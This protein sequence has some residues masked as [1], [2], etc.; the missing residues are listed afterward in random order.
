MV[1]LSFQAVVRQRLEKHRYELVCLHNFRFLSYNIGF[2]G[3]Y[4]KLDIY[5]GSDE[6]ARVEPDYL[7]G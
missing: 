5:F 7:S 4:K 3:I 2:F 1:S 6:N